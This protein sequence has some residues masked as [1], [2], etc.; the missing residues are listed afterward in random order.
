VGFENMDDATWS[1]MEKALSGT[2]KV[3][4]DYT[5]QDHAFFRFDPMDQAGG[6]RAKMVAALGD[7]LSENSLASGV[8]SDKSNL[9]SRAGVSEALRSVLATLH[10][11]IDNNPGLQGPQADLM[12]EAMT[13]KF[14]SMLPE[15]STKLASIKRMGIPGYDGDFQGNFARRAGGGVNDTA[16]I[17]S[18]P[19]FAA[20]FK[21]IGS[22]MDNLSRA[23][24][25]EMQEK[26]QIVADE[27][28]TRH[29][30]S[31][32]PVDNSTVNLINSLGH[33]FYLAVAPAFYIRTMAQPWHRGIP[34]LGARYGFANASKE[35]FGATP[36]SLKIIQQ[37]IAQ[38][39]ASDGLAGLAN[40]SMKFKDMGLSPREE[41]FIQDLHDSGDLKLGQAQQLQKMIIGGSQK[42]QDLTRAASMTA[43]YAEM[44]NRLITGL[45]AFRL[46]EKGRPDVTQ[47]GYD[48]NVKYARNAI[49]NAMDNFDS[50]NTARDIGKNGVFGKV[51]PL[52]TQFMNYSMQTMQQIARTVH[53]GMFNRDQSP[54]GLQRSKEAK[55]EFAGLFATTAMISGA[56]GL[57]FVNAAAG[58]Y[59]MLTQDDDNPTDI[60]QSA[61]NGLADMFGPEIGNVLSHGVGAA[62]GVDTSTFGLQNLLPGSEFIASRRLLKDRLDDLSTSLLGPAL[63]GAI[64][65]ANAGVKISDGYYMKG[66]EAALPSG[67]KGYFKAWELSDKGYTDSKGNPIGLKATPA[68]IAWQSVGL[69]PEDKAVQA[70]AQQ[71]SMA[72]QE[73]LANRSNVI[74]THIMQAQGDPEALAS[75]VQ[76]MRDYNKANPYQPITADALMNTVRQHVMLQATGQLSGTG[77]GA[78]N[79]KQ[80]T[81]QNQKLRFARGANSAMP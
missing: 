14:L 18:A 25:P 72:D 47:Q 1:K 21:Q 75:A 8:L 60:R 10:E 54:E 77:V 5:N 40:G 6:M 69:R 73:R 55:K 33:S 44:T 68:D 79:V 35:M 13:R 16:N 27:I 59:N 30:N 37:S 2:N 20:A 23:G 58:V 56:M 74:R 70:E 71:Y 28:N 3:L 38:G 11:S 66:I 17:Y 63:N 51:T 32:Q 26:G 61:R 62:I 19:A 4:G 48:A 36:V 67:L 12:K 22:A 53:D 49:V 65:I 81:V 76:E 41:Q 43:Q 78:T 29:A 42:V 9:S 45:S 46:A 50:Y 52:A 31:M 39:W 15:T 80:Y 7:K 34:I 24:N 57:P 64:D